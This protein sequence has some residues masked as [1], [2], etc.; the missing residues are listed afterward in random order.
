MDNVS[1]LRKRIAL[2][3]RS[4]GLDVGA[5]DYGDARAWIGDRL[6]AFRR[7]VLEIDDSEGYQIDKMRPEDHARFDEYLAE[8]AAECQ[9][10]TND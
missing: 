2:Y 1:T 3:A 6:L 4:Q 8:R 7:E 10:K 9:K 5:V